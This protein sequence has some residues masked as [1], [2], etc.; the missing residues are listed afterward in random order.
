[1]RADT[2]EQV[3]NVLK[4][5]IDCTHQTAHA[6]LPI[7]LDEY[8]KLTAA[9]YQHAQATQPA[10]PDRLL[11]VKEVAAMLNVKPRTIHEWIAQGKIPVRRA[12]AEPRFKR[13]EILEWTENQTQQGHKGRMRVVK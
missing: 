6:L 11:T 4:R 12:G 1:M 10:Q 13:E 2:R 3:S 5:F 7:A 8:E 9:R